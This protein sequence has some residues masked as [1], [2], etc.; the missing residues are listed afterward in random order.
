MST[1][2]REHRRILGAALTTVGLTNHPSEWWHCSY[3]DRYWAYLTG[4][5]A[6]R[7]GP[8]SSAAL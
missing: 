8:V 2:A 7:Y 3:G 6:A 4:A 1:E 5:P